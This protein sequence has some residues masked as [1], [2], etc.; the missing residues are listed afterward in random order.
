MNV[1]D[2]FDA[3]TGARPDLRYYLALAARNALMLASVP[4]VFAGTSFL[5]ATTK[6]DTYRSTA[7]VVLRPNDPN[8]RLGSDGG[9]GADLGNIE[10]YVRAQ[11][12][13]AEGPMIRERVATLLDLD[14]DDVEDDLTVSALVDSNTLEITTEGRSPQSAKELADAVAETFITNRRESAVE[15][16]TRAVADIDERLVALKTELRG[17]STA[18]ESASIQAQLATAQQQF[19]D[20]SGKK[21]DLEIDLNLKR[22]EAELVAPAELP[23]DPFAPQP[24]R[25]GALGALLGLVVTVGALL[26]RDRLDVRLRDTDAAV[27][28]TGL[29][30]LIEVPFDKT[31]AKHPW[32]ISTARDPGGAVAE[33]MRSLR[34]SLRF[35]SLEHPVKVVLVT[36]AVPGDGK[37]TIAS[38]LAVSFAKSGARTLLVSADLRRP[39][40]ERM[41]GTSNERGLAELLT[42]MATPEPRPVAGGERAFT[43]AKAV[44]S[45]VLEERTD[46][47][48]S[49]RFVEI[50]DWCDGNREN[51][52]VLP[53]GQRVANPLELLTLDATRRFVELAREQFDITIVDSAPVDPVS[54][55]LVIAPLVDGSIVVVRVG[56]TP[57]PALARSVA[58]LRSSQTRCLG[59]VANRIP[60]RRRSG[61]RGYGYGYGGSPD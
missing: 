15:G 60:V 38:N 4:L 40:A 2:L 53:A 27:R 6:P 5:L 54:D 31:T 29:P 34:V 37:S 59:L 13:L 51:L 30:S 18:A 33:A 48:R 12:I 46:T 41:T 23:D 16:L 21:I 28:T 25:S 7:K 39:T 58:R 47:A 36:S 1:A 14:P 52:W 50:R 24:L 32:E 44:N 45:T 49:E 55:S 22:G 17:L 35:A 8:E 42:V 9:S 10:H 3:E 19:A 43:V 56:S 57:T 11:A 20:L 26:L 61:Y